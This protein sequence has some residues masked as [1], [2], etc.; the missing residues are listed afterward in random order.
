[1]SALP[2]RVARCLER[3]LGSDFPLSC[4]PGIGALLAALAAAVPADGRILELGTGAGV[5]LAWIAEG[6][7]GRSDVEVVSVELAPEVAALA[8]EESW[9]DRFCIVVGNGA[10]EV[11]RHGRFD[12]IFADAPGG[13]LHGLEHT[14]NALTPGG[15]LLVDDMDP[16]L[17][18]DD[19]YR[20]PLL[21]V[22]DTLVAHPDL[23][24][25]ELDYSSGAIV[26]VRS[27]RT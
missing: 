22:R 10:V 16:A 25:A 15:V 9:P 14:V 26:S 23:V 6:L 18:G 3:A 11:R 7:S 12:L 13:K 5:G 4:E 27:S 1:M 8:R 17:H 19:G 2:A 21:Q 20:A 24:T